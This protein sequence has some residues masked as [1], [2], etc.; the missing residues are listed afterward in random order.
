MMTETLTIT[1]LNCGFCTA[2]NHCAA[3]GGELSAALE[4]KPGIAR[5]QVNVPDH[6]LL[7][8]HDMDSGDLEDLLDGRGLLI[9]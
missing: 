4:Q 9:G 6:T 2:K 8:E 3:C 7:V 1:Y 5:A